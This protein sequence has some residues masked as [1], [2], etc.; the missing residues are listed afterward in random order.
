MLRLACAAAIGLAF[1]AGEAHAATF[2]VVVVPGLSLADL[3]RL[4][5]R[6]AVGLLVPG[7]GSRTSRALAEA[8]LV[9]A[10]V[11][12]S[13]NGSAHG[14]VL[15]RL[16]TGAVPA[17]GP[18]IVLGLPRDGSEPND[19]RYP[20]AVLGH[21]YRGLL[22][23]RSTRIA[24]L[25]AIDDVAPTALGRPDR[26]RWR[27]EPHA[28]AKAAALDD[29]IEDHRATRKPAMVLVLGLAAV[30]ALLFPRAG[31]LA[32]PA[33]L[34]ANLALG[35]FGITDLAATLVVLG[36]AVAAG[37]PLAALALRGPTALGGAMAAA[38]AAY[39]VGLAIDGSWIGFS[40]L[41]P[42][43]VGRYYGLS[44]VLETIALV[45]ALAGAALLWRRFG[46]LGLAAMAALALVTVSGSRFGAD[47][48]GAIVLAVGYA[49]LAVGLARA[50][51]RALAVAI[52]LAAAIV[53]VFVAV[54]AATGAS[55]HVTG[56]LHGGF[57]GLADDLRDRAELSYRVAVSSWGV[58]LGCAAA[59]AAFAAIA[60]VGLRA[61][62]PPPD[63][64]L[65]AAFVVAIATSLFVNDTPLDI[66]LAGL[67]GLWVLYRWTTQRDAAAF[68][69]PPRR[70]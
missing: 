38:F 54:D 63:R 23:S 29:R 3:S 12:N 69:W 25:A 52:P 21:G 33:A 53:L 44:N 22:T 68:A 66:A 46:A 37:A 31:L 35:A 49:V 36:L 51:R 13:A 15:L 7:A 39:L 61:D 27:A 10:K 56:A 60:F 62:V 67:T 20:I 14:P 28:A 47:G 32:F 24:G 26:L 59:L 42:G 30:L 19:R 17:R 18:A 41:G 9:R 6:G 58:G 57:G 55:S 4:E 43:M 50:P 45:P 64:A 2:R 1:A 5:T 11:S 34:A 16:S 65:L 70:R 8:G 48:G 40:P